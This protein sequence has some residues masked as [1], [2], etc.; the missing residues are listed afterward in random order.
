MI[1][2]GRIKVVQAPEA[3]VVRAIHVR[4][5]DR[6]R[7]GDPIIELDPTSALAGYDQIRHDLL[8]A[9]LDRARM[10]ALSANPRAPAEAYTVPADA[11]AALLAVQRRLMRGL[12]AEYQAQT[13]SAQAELARRQSE[14]RSL[15]AQI[16][17]LE[18]SIPL[19]SKRVEAK[20]ILFDKGIGA[21]MPLLEMKQQLSDQQHDLAIHNTRRAE[22]HSGIQ[23][24]ESQLRRIRAEFERKVES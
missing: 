5:G 16:A 15:L 17:K 9:Q 20:Q 24:A 12:A 2:S 22:V 23:A 13:D 14:A 10:T 18:A 6:V 8:L 21:A 4:D 7:A 3:G 19:L 1:P 11:P